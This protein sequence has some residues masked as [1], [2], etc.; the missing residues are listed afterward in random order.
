MD[1]P[2]P[3]R[4]TGR[5][6][7]SRRFESWQTLL[8]GWV[9]PPLVVLSLAGSK[10]PTY[11]L[12]L[13]PA[14]A[15]LAASVAFNLRRIWAVAVAAAAV[16]ILGDFGLS[17]NDGL[18]RKPASS[19][20]LVEALRE[21]EPDADSS[22]LFA[23]ETRA[24]GFAYYS[25]RK[26]DIT[27]READLVLDPTPEQSLTL[28]SSVGDCVERLTDGPPAHGIVNTSRFNKSFDPEKWRVI[29]TSGAFSLVANHPA[30][31]L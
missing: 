21:R 3:W 14:F 6:I 28:F 20:G 24:E 19:R 23:C 26:L 8:I 13:L 25:K 1:F 12:P 31:P 29:A 30:H 4:A 27:N 9:I 5:R 16:F 22:I 7:R 15:L 17:R 10:L 18:L 11:V 2:L